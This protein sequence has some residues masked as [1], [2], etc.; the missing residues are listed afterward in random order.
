MKNKK[1]KNYIVKTT[2]KTIFKKKKTEFC[3]HL[4][5]GAMEVSLRERKKSKDL[6]RR[7]FNPNFERKSS[8][9]ESL[10]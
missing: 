2:T 1:D 10:L 6:W 9:F 3:F 5:N 4:Q 8:N 7:N